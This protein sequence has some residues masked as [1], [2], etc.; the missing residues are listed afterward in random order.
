MA[1]NFA[2]C[3][4]VFTIKSHSIWTTFLF[5]PLSSCFWALF[6]MF[7][8]E[9]VKIVYP[10]LLLHRWKALRIHV[11]YVLTCFSAYPYQK[12]S[13]V[14]LFGSNR[15]WSVTLSRYHHSKHIPVR[16]S[17]SQLYSWPLWEIANFCSTRIRSCG[18]CRRRNSFD[19]SF[20]SRNT[21]WG[22]SIFAEAY[23]LKNDDTG[24]KKYFRKF[25]QV[26]YETFV[27]QRRLWICICT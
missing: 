22:F 6:S 18:Q 12:K 16:S 13:V 14:G 9:I 10:R 20:L 25:V 8:A 15:H 27:S 17:L 7:C 11:I 23:T 24:Y 26:D 2:Y 5:S 4:S 3:T 21:F 1:S 19:V